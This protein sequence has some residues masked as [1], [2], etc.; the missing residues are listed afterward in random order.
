MLDL[1]EKLKALRLKRGLSQAQVAELLGITPA[2]VSSYECD[3][4]TPTLPLLVRFASLYRVSTDYLLGIH[5]TKHQVLDLD[6]LT[7]HEI[8]LLTDLADTFRSARN[9]F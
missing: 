2:A 6:G 4:R 8:E 1:S 5:T 7:P 9:I 3:V